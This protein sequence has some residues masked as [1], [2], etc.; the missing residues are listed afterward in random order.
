MYPKQQTMRQIQ[1]DTGLRGNAPA[2]DSGYSV[3]SKDVSLQIKEGYQPGCIG[4]IASLH[5][6]FYSENWG[7]GVFFEKK[8]ATDLAEFAE[9]LPADGKALWLY[10][11]NGRA[12]ASLAIDGDHIKGVAHLRWFIVDESLRG[13]GVGRHLMSRAMQFVDSRFQETYLWTFRGLD[14][15]RHLYESSG[16]RLTQQSEGTQWGTK[17]I[18]QRFNRIRAEVR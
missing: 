9:A 16:F 18:E 6:R 5:A 15:A 1:I 4:D 7:F 10:V 17:V 13:T 2:S 12:L 3:S 8:V 14:A 11:E